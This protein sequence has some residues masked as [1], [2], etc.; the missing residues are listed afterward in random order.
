MSTYG[1]KHVM[2]APFAAEDPEP[3]NSLP[4]YAEAFELG[5]LNKVTD[6]PVFNEAK[7]YG[8][9]AL[10]RYVSEFKENPIDVEIL[11]MTVEHA[12]VV[13]GAKIDTEGDK[14]THFNSEDN[15]PYGG[16]AFYI[17]ELLANN[18]KKYRGIFYP[19]AKAVMQGE[20]YTTKG[21]SI[22]LEN[23]K[24]RFMGAAAKNGDWK[25]KSDR[26]DTE[27]EAQ[28]WVEKMLGVVT[29]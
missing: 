22:T 21:D 8:S 3:A 29:G 24:L 14:T 10:G 4:N 2:F 6:A 23:E 11:D 7:A 1:A 20:T 12:S 13:T 5:E 28:A 15:A 17:N 19:K 27:A 16:L 26:F 25:L 9:N 18:V